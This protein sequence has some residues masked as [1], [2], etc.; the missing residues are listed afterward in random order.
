MNGAKN[1][2]RSEKQFLF[3]G[4]LVENCLP[5]FFQVKY[6]ITI[7]FSNMKHFHFNLQ[8][9]GGVGKS[10]LTYLLALK[11]EDNEQSYFV[12]F[13]SS[14]K[15]STQ[16]LK[17]LQGRP[18]P[19]FAQRNLLDERGKIDRQRLFENLQTLVQ[20]EYKDFYLDFGAPESE[21]FSSLFSKDYS[22]EEFKQI[23]QELNGE[24]IFNIVVAGG[25]SY[26]PST[27]YLHNIVQL[28]KQNFCINIF[29]NE[30][31][32]QK[33]QPLFVEIE[34]YA[35]DNNIHA[36]KY[37]GDFDTEAAPH[38]NILKNIAEGRG[39]DAYIFIEKIKIQK[40]LKKL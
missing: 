13:D 15:S 12:D 4:R 37:F 29:V 23:E 26:L 7:N 21:Q 9:K 27:H 20:K 30:F 17:F 16:Q 18:P 32:F 14:V 11:N 5:F 31:T 19:R 33:N 22:V 6:F 2:S 34:N 28:N 8:S 38:Q 1:N 25:S 40:E 36:V 39:M 24:F 10:M 35:K 3:W